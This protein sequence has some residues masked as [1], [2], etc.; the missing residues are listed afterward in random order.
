M[1]AVERISSKTDY[2]SVSILSAVISF[3]W[4]MEPLRMEKGNIRKTVRALAGELIDVFSPP[5]V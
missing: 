4:E 2:T 1:R 3:Q 5:K